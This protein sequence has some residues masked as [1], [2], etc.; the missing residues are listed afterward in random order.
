MII[1][2]DVIGISPVSYLNG[3]LEQEIIE[4]YITDEEDII[5]HTKNHK[6]I[7]FSL[8]NSYTT[9]SLDLEYIFN[10]LD[11]KETICG[12][13]GVRYSD[14]H[15][16]CDYVVIGPGE[17][18]LEE[19]LNGSILPRIYVENR[20][21]PSQFK[22]TNKAIY[23]IKQGYCKV[24]VETFKEC[25]WDKCYFCDYGSYSICRDSDLDFNSA[26]NIIKTM[27]EVSR[28]IKNYNGTPEIHCT[29]A[30]IN[31]YNLN[32]L[33][34]SM[35]KYK[36]NE[37][38]W[39]ISLRPEREFIDLLPKISNA[40]GEL[41][42]G[43]EFLTD[44]DVVNKGISPSN[45]MEFTDYCAKNNVRIWGNFLY[46]VPLTN[47]SDMVRNVENIDKI[48]NNLTTFQM[49]CVN[50]TGNCEYGRNPR[51]YGIKIIDS[52]LSF[53]STKKYDKWYKDNMDMIEEISKIINKPII[54]IKQPFV[55]NME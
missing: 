21:S 37:Y 51:K 22:L 35:E 30:S 17:Y 11:N 55:Y 47:K 43:I 36:D 41:S 29:H 18:F 20:P 23:N 45:I 46:F 34:N 53:V 42:L 31:K 40:N 19:F 3:Y 52:N 44:R 49:N 27:N 2:T 9:D 14:I 54:S 12:G 32:L 28:Q 26:A 1:F 38:S 7:G 15:K 16:Y 25:Y 8:H 39:G 24:S 48:K 10:Q 50:L 6:I 33:V 13:P 5:N 4:E